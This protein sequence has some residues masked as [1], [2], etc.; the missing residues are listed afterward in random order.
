MSGV[1]YTNMAKADKYLACNEG[2]MRQLHSATHQQT[3]SSHC[4]P[5][6]LLHCNVD[7]FLQCESPILA[8]YHVFAGVKPVYNRSDC[9]TSFVAL[10]SRHCSSSCGRSA[11]C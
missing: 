5:H 4:G 10:Q 9:L 2:H 7:A 3:Y 8:V 11:Q 6:P 1:Q